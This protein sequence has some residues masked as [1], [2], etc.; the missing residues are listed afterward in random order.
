MKKAVF[1]DRD[2]TIIEENGFICRL[3]EG[4][5]FPFSFEAIR[6]MN[7]K[8]YLVFCVTNQSA[9]ARGICTKEEVEKIHQQL[10]HTFQHHQAEIHGFYYSPY[11][12]QGIVE[13]YRQSHTWRKPSPGM[14][15]QAA[16]DFAID[17]SH[18]YMIGDSVIDIQAGKNAGCQTV[19]VL[20]GKGYQTREELE[21]LNLCPD[22]TVDNILTAALKIM[23][24][25]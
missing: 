12:P 20:T 24:L 7:Q 11:H 21:S 8:G 10:Y 23:P 5:I 25:S 17:L 9:V 13:E 3:P 15:L 4:A 1:L 16:K 19:L 14:L 22:L 18:S 2:G 6:L